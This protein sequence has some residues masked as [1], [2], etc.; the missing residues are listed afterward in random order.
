VIRRAIVLVLFVICGAAAYQFIFVDDKVEP[1]LVST[2]PTSVIGFGSSAVGVAADGSVLT[3]LPAPKESLPQLPFS[4]PPPGAR[5]AGPALQQARVLGAAP[6]SLRPYIESSFYG[7]SGVD[8]VLKAG[9]QLRFGDASQAAKKWRAATAVIADPAVVTLDY[10][11]LLAP[12]RPTIGGAGHT[13]PSV[14]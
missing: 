13:L 7:D 5:L 12:E 4:E 14:P 6:P 11:N 3:W 8:V 10:I 1:R 9:V 2:Q